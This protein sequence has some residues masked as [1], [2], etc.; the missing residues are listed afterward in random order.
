MTRPSKGQVL[1]VGAVKNKLIWI[2]KALGVGVG[3]DLFVGEPIAIDLGSHEG[4]N[5]S[6]ARML[7]RLANRGLEIGRQIVRALE[8]SWNPVRIMLKIAQHF[9]KI[10]RPFF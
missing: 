6:L 7:P 10:G 1:V 9:R 3:Y 4:V 2:G 8:N 5:Q